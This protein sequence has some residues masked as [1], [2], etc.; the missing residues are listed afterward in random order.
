MAALSSTFVATT[1]VPPEYSDKNHPY[2]SK[3]AL[4][5]APHLGVVEEG[6]D[7]CPALA[8]GE[9]GPLRI[10]ALLH[11]APLHSQLLDLVDEVLVAV[12]G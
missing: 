2:L 9:Q 1:G 8:R 4:E 6:R 3:V 11:L 10:V 7:R 5:H 12:L